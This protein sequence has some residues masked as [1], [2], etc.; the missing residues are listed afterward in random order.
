ML[1][2]LPIGLGASYYG[3]GPGVFA[4]FL[5]FLAFNFFFVEPLYTLSVHRTQDLIGLFVF[6]GTAFAIGRGF[7]MARQNLE[8][9]QAREHEAIRLSEFSSELAGLHDDKAIAQALERKVL[10]TFLAQRVEIILEAQDIPDVGAPSGQEAAGRS[11]DPVN[12]VQVN[13]NLPRRAT[14]RFAGPFSRLHVA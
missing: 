6:L 5:A 7:G 4:A 11:N 8:K 14:T 10:E 12:P 13:A 3:L 1:Y 2:L 9:A